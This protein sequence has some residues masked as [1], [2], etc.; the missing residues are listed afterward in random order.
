MGALG[1]A[2]VSLLDVLVAR[3]LWRLTSGL[4]PRASSVATALRYGAGVVQGT[5]SVGLFLVPAPSA[6]EILRFDRLWGAGLVVLALHLVTLAA[7]L[8]LNRAPG[9]VVVGTAAAGVTHLL[10]AR[11]GGVLL[12]LMVGELLLLAWLLVVGRTGRLSE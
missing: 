9:V 10:G 12:P 5:A 7:A 1:F 6:A 11:P 8:R 4:A 2:I 3:H